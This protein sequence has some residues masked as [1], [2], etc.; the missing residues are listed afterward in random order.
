MDHVS[1]VIPNSICLF[2][3]VSFG[4]ENILEL[5]EQDNYLKVR[6]CSIAQ[7]I[8]YTAS[9]SRELTPKVKHVGL[10]LALH[11]A[12]CSEKMVNI[13][14]AAGLTVGIYTLRRIDSSIANDTKHFVGSNGNYFSHGLEKD[15]HCKT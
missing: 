8:V 14:H 2:L 10:G 3:S 5:E 6:I 9:K 12:T 1:D 15:H 7:D 4:G 13:F 11:Q